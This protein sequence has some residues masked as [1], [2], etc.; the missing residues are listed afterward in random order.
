MILAHW[1]SRLQLVQQP[2]SVYQ[3]NIFFKF[4]QHKMLIF[5]PLCWL[6]KTQHLKVI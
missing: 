6:T 3:L 5:V 4:S 1:I 2:F